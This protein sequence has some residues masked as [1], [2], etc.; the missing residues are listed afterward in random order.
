VDLQATLAAAN[1]QTDPAP[2]PHHPL[3]CREGRLWLD[4]DGRMGCEH[5][6]VPADD[7]RTR[8]CIDHSVA[9]LL[10]EEAAKL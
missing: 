4:D 3:A 1:P 7:R 10:L 9:I 8:G 2:V 6:Q 5:A